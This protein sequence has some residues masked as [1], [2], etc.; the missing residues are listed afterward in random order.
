MRKLQLY[1]KN[2]RVDLFKDESVSLTQ[3]IKNVK[4]IAKVFTE[5]TQ[6]FSIPAS[7]V[8]NKIFEHYYDFDIIEGFD[9]RIKVDAKLELNDLPFKEGKIALQ[10][11]D[12]KNN[13]AHTYKITFF[14][15]TVNLKDLLGDSALSSLPL[16]QNQIYDYANVTARM[17]S[18]SNDIL[19]PLIT[20]TNRLVYNSGSETVYDPEATTNNLYPSAGD[21]GK[22]GVA[23]DE[24][25][26]AIR[27]QAIIDAIESRYNITFSNDFFND[28]TNEKFHNLFMWLHRKTGSVQAPAQVEVIYTRLTD[29]V[30][31][32]GSDEI[33]STVSNGVITIPPITTAAETSIPLFL[34][35]T[36]NPVDDA[37]VYNVRVIRD[38]SLVI[39]ELNGVN[40]TQE[41][42]ILGGGGGFLIRDATYT[43]EIAGIGV[44]FNAN[45]IDVKL[46]YSVSFDE[47]GVDLYHNNAFFQ[48]NQDFEFNITEQIPKI[49]IIDFLSGLFNMFN[50]T[51]YVENDIIVVRTLD[52]YYADS[53]TVYNI[54]KYIDTTKSTIDVALPFKQ[55]N[56]SYKGL[57]SF[58]AK[59]FE[60][61]TNSGWGSLGFTL[62]GN[63][64]DATS[65][66]YKVEVPF[67]HFQY[68]RLYD[69]GTSPRDATDVQWGYSVNETQQPYIGLPLLFYPIY[70]SNGTSIRIRNTISDAIL[71]IDDYFIPSNS[72]KLLPST[73][74]VNIHFQN[75][76]NE[77]LAN[78]PDSIVAGNNALGFTNTLFET[79]YKTYIQDVFNLSRRLTKVTAYLPM[80][81]YYNLELNDLIEIGQDR[82]KINSLTTD[83]TTGKTEFELLNTIL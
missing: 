2:Q 68:E 42:R 36:L 73:S 79:E 50:L 63:I 3:T 6:T 58:L 5:F 66:S 74:K 67:E 46:T 20:H 23:W 64:Y 53:T 60:Q 12:L 8:N 52:S 39:A 56:F 7:S 59:Q 72:L 27:L 34:D 69:F 75:E 26:F 35:Y 38:G 44:S 76:F 25:K 14:G 49:K 70:I 18:S 82:Y 16:N 28:N 47:G 71:D 31:K 80:K 54:D 77:Y 83:L 1:I 81:V 33:L 17:Q 48:T 45:D 9:A 51:A 10:G 62:D 11:V 65:E 41:I 32:A 22:N 19:V 29:L 43:L 57:G 40:N 55:I 4:D 15:N 21:N 37:A 78:E 13:L 30:V 61:L 24:F